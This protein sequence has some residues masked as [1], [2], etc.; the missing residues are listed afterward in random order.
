MAMFPAQKSL[1]C[2][3]GSILQQH[4]ET[5]DEVLWLPSTIE[6]SMENPNS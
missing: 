2:L 6:T 4:R 3:K 5:K 1:R